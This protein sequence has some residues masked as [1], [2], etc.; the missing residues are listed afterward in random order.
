MDD[1]PLKELEEA[2][3]ALAESPH[4]TRVLRSGDTLELSSRPEGPVIQ[5]LFLLMVIVPP[6][7][8]LLEE[9]S[10][11]AGVA[12]VLWLLVIGSI[13]YKLIRAD[14]SA[15]FDLRAGTVEVRSVNPLVL[16]ERKLLPLRFPWEGRFLW[17]RFRR[18]E[19]R[20]KLY[21]KWSINRGHRLFFVDSEGK[22][23]QFAEFMKAEL[24]YT[25]A[26]AI[27]R[28]TGTEYGKG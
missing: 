16:L 7:G 2:V 24:A 11:S 17:T 4:E 10:A 22:S 20:E 15:L 3:R 14:M 27:A 12:A 8:V 6:A 1:S 13:Y 18:V 9:Q 26:R 19:V 28:V 23:I 21:G 5:F 25:A